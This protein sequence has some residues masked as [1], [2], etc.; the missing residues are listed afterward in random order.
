MLPGPNNLEI[1]WMKDVTTRFE[2]EKRT[3]DNLDLPDELTFHLT[4]KSNV[5]NLN[6]KRNWG[7]DPNAEV[8]VVRTMKDG[9][10]QMEKTLDI[11]K[12][13]LAYYQ[14]RDNGAFLTVKCVKKSNGQS[15]RVIN[16]NIRI[17]DKDYD[18]QVA[19]D[20]VTP[21][22]VFDV[23]DRRGTQYVL[24]E[25]SN[26]E[27]SALAERISDATKVNVKHVK[28]E[29]KDLRHHFPLE[30]NNQNHFRLTN[31]RNKASYYN[32]RT[33]D[34][35]N[36]LFYW[37]E[38]AVMADS[39]VWDLFE[40]LTEAHQMQT[41]HVDDITAEASR[42]I[43][44][45]F[46]HIINGV[47]MRYK[48]INDPGIE[49]S[50]TLEKIVIFQKENDIAFQDSLI[51]LRHGKT[52]VY[53]DKYLDS[54][55]YRDSNFGLAATHDHIML[56]TRHILFDQSIAN[57]GINGRSEFYGICIPGK[58]ISVIEIHD[59][60]D[61]VHTATHELG[62]NLGAHHDGEGNA[63]D[64]PAEDVFIMTPDLPIFEPG[65]PYSRNPWLFSKCSLR[66]FKRTLKLGDCLKNPGVFYNME[67]WKNVTAKPPGQA[68]S[69]TE[70]CQ[71]ISG[72]N[73]VFC[74]KVSAKIC[75]DLQ[76]TDPTTG[77]CFDTPFSAAR[78]TTCGSDM[79]CKEGLCVEQQ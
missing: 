41:N 9:Q 26:I 53:A 28:Q 2:T 19:E 27:R 11:K 67:E 44:E 63:I 74:G 54:I 73:S 56:F 33:K 4:S 60:F 38:M 62:H 45:Y 42:R 13:N 20:D 6:L 43:R 25:Q 24:R 66:T 1:V 70:Q 75:L 17:G 5:L 8:Y 3:H 69:Y 51:Q 16:G 14:D 72:P 50:V 31:S 30:Q 52:Y 36:K 47:H 46:S 35:R 10:P 39:S 21:R 78:G 7:I 29:F 68:Y 65:E 34:K 12:E 22:S 61:T 15:D 79:W 23:P 77:Q 64:C 57:D 40:S 59:Y 55:G 49:I 37:I 32:G 58:I 76:C 18:V 71:L 48:E